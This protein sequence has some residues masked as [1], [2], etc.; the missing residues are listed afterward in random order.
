AG[1]DTIDGGQGSDTYVY[2]AGDGYDRI[3]ETST[4]AGETDTLRLSGLNL[5]D[6]SLSRS[7]TD[8]FVKVVATGHVIT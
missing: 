6:L 7:A 8:L 1:D 5:A 3:V 4:T 2:A